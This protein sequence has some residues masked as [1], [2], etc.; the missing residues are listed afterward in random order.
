MITVE[1]AEKIVLAESKDYGTERVYFE[2]A[3]GR[4]LAENISADRDLPPYNRA[5]MDGIAINYAAIEN[6]I[7]C[8]KIVAT[9]AAGDVP[10]EI[11]HPS[12][13]VA[14]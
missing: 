12:E 7:R 8:F 5:T 10:F 14:F 13:C 1:E 6:D 11:N 3:L 4:V 2:N 9:Q